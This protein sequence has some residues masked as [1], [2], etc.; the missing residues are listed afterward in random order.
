MWSL[1]VYAKLIT[2]T[3]F[4]YLFVAVPEGVCDLRCEMRGLRYGGRRY[5]WDGEPPTMREAADEAT[6]LRWLKNVVVLPS[7]EYEYLKQW[8]WEFGYNDQGHLETTEGHGLIKNGA[9]MNI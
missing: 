9:F 7:L 8:N 3:T 1:W 5:W 4:M 6:P 2:L